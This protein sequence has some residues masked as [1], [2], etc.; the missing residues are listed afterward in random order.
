[1]KRQWVCKIVSTKKIQNDAKGTV[2]WQT[3][4][5]VNW[6]N[7]TQRLLKVTW[8]VNTSSTA[9]TKRSHLSTHT[10]C[11]TQIP[12]SMCVCAKNL[13]KV[14][15]DKSQNQK[16]KNVSIFCR[17]FYSTFPLTAKSCTWQWKKTPSLVWR[18]HKPLR[19]HPWTHSSSHHEE[20]MHFCTLSELL[21][22]FWDVSGECEHYTI[23]GCLVQPTEKQIQIWLHSLALGSFP[24]ADFCTVW[25]W[26][27][28]QSIAYFEKSSLSAELVAQPILFCQ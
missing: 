9:I 19:T 11:C 3:A 16:K 7:I 20:Y 23:E 21:D 24:T 2:P 12:V 25:G 22:M 27:I 14:W 17:L 5:W 18:K 1:M 26:W 4:N 13:K 6:K 8:N 10:V 15:A 28:A